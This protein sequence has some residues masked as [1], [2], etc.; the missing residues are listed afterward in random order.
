MLELS[1]SH[2]SV[3]VDNS[4]GNDSS[5]TVTVSM[6]TT[7]LICFWLGEVKSHL[8]VVVVVLYG[9]TGA[10]VYE[11]GCVQGKV[12]EGVCGWRHDPQRVPASAAG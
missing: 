2:F 5:F 6:V 8:P 7:L 4:S 1:K 11:P 9:V 10:A 3:M 12:G